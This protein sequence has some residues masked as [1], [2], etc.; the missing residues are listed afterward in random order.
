[1]PELI[2]H[3]IIEVK[4]VKSFCI[5]CFKFFRAD[6]FKFTYNSF[7][8]N[9]FQPYQHSFIKMLFKLTLILVLIQGLQA[10]TGMKNFQFLLLRTHWICAFILDLPVSLLRVYLLCRDPVMPLPNILVTFFVR[11]QKLRKF[12]DVVYEISLITKAIGAFPNKHNAIQ[13]L[14]SIDI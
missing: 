14:P 9:F 12:A 6:T 5:F 4:I 2:L 1:M 7:I 11:V 13:V 8:H 10:Q 3:Y